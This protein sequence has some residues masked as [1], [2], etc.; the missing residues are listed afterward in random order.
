MSGGEDSKHLLQM[1]PDW[2]KASQERQEAVSRLESLNT[3]IH[4]LISRHRYP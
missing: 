3:P 2:W 4:V 1:T